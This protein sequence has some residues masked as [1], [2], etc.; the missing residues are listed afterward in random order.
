MHLRLDHVPSQLQMVDGTFRK[1]SHQTSKCLLFSNKWILRLLWTA[2]AHHNMTFQLHLSESCKHCWKYDSMP[3][4]VAAKPTKS[5]L[6]AQNHKFLYD[7][8]NQVKYFRVLDR[9]EL[10]HFYE[11]SP[12]PPIFL[13]IVSKFALECA[14]LN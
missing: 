11:D 7:L 6:L 1:R 5:S 2:L 13:E 14:Y 10:F 8:L 4:V 12:S 3:S 9:D